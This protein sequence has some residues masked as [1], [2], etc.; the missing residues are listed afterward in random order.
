MGVQ[1]PAAHIVGLIPAR[2]K[3]SRFPGKPL[4]PLAGKPLLQHVHE[5]ALACQ[6]LAEVAVATDDDRIREAAEAWGARVIMTSP[7]HPTGTDRLAEAVSHLPE[8]THVINLQGDEPLL[9]PALVDEM[10]AA[11]TTDPELAM[12][13]AANPLED[14]AEFADPNVVKVVLDASGHAL[15]FSRCP[16]PYARAEEDRPGLLRHMG[17]YGYRR[18]FLARFVAWEPTPLE[19]SEQLEQLRAL[20]NGVRIRVLITNHRA[21]GLDT[22]DQAPQL[23]ALLLQS[24]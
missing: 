8:A 17:L 22:P 7:D 3:S 13:T 14:A 20:E 6:S 1:V 4:H 18:D 2:W 10:A 23:E 16:I 12:I 11:L 24:S 5:R 9:D 15:Y 21:L 19:R